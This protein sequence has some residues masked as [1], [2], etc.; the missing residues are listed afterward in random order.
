MSVL[1]VA[2]VEVRL[3]AG[4]TYEVEPTTGV[5]TLDFDHFSGSIRLTPATAAQ[6]ASGK[7]RGDE[8]VDPLAGKRA[9]TGTPADDSES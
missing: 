7:R 9:R 8:D 3:P 4:V 6:H 2:G 1:A 5:V